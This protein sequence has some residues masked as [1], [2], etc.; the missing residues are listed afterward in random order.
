M[1]ASVLA[2]RNEVL[3]ILCL[4]GGSVFS[5]SS[6]LCVD[7]SATMHFE[8]R[9]CGTCS[10]AAL[11][12]ELSNQAKLSVDAT[13]VASFGTSPSIVSFVESHAAVKRDDGSLIH[14]TISNYAPLLHEC[15][16]G[17]KWNEAV[18]LARYVA[19]TATMF[20]VCVIHVHTK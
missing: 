15:T 16:S 6:W 17:G 18:R 1:F 5:G 8:A 14:A 20:A 2:G 11:D 13:V 9:F 7:M 3:I 4:N 19:H 12:T 10:Y